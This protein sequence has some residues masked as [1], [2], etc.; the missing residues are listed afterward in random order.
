M[1]SEHG[2][3]AVLVALFLCI[4]VP[5]LMLVLETGI[6]SV[7]HVQHQNAA[8]AGALAGALDLGVWGADPTAAARTYAMANG[9][10]ESDVA[11]SLV[12]WGDP[13]EPAILVRVG[14]EVAVAVAKDGGG[15]A[16]VQ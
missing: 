16:L 2:A 11:V 9:A 7:I 12:E 3:V 8:D 13:P 14:N 4:L 1:R 10:A 6:K 5:M 15:S